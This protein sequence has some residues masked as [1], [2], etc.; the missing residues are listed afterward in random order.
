MG[1]DTVELIMA[2]EQRFGIE[3]AN[4]EAER[5]TTVGAIHQLVIAKLRTRGDPINEDELYSQLRDVICD[6]LR[7]KPEAATPSASIVDDLGAD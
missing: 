3:I 6:Q 4:A 1:L 2:V 7:M 5:L